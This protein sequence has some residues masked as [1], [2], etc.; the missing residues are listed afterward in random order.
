MIY[1]NWGYVYTHDC[2]YSTNKDT[3]RDP[4]PH[5]GTP[6]KGGDDWKKLTGRLV[7]DKYPYGIRREFK[8][9]DGCPVDVPEITNPN[10]IPKPIFNHANGSAN[11]L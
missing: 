6:Y 1:G 10:Q 2:G 3:Y 8:D 7:W 4:C 5:C 11:G 9:L